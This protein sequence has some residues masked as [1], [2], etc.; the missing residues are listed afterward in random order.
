MADQPHLKQETILRLLEGFQ[1]SEKGIG[2]VVWN[3][4]IGNPV[5]FHEKYREELLALEGDTGGKRV[6][7]R[8]LEDVYLCEAEEKTELKDYDYKPK[9]EAEN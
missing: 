1:R 4:Q 5:I 7:K 2:A 9:E 8:H 6:L 3:E